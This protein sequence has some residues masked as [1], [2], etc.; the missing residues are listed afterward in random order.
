MERGTSG[1]RSSTQ[2]ARSKLAPPEAKSGPKTERKPTLPEASGM[3]LGTTNGHLW[4]PEGRFLARNGPPHAQTAGPGAGPRRAQSGPKAGQN[5]QKPFPR[6]NDP[7]P[8]GV[9]V[10]VFLARF[11]AGSGGSDCRYVAKSLKG[12][13]AVGD[14]KRVRSGPQ[15]RFP[16]CAPGPTGVPERLCLAR[17]V[18]IS[19]CLDILSVPATFGR[20]KSAPNLYHRHK[21]CGKR[22]SR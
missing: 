5:H 19:G 12:E 20:A 14:H 3:G 16:S 9:T 15:K 18:A 13:R 10:D 11:Q 1:L 17:F 2:Q 8:L 21:G 22:T 7:G 4:A 6:K